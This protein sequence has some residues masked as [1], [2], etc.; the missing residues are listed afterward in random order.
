M[1]IEIKTLTG[2]LSEDQ[3]KFR[4]RCNSHMETDK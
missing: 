4:E 3:E 1:Y 2:R